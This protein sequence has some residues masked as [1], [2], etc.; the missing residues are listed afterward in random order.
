MKQNALQTQ[1]RNCGMEGYCAIPCSNENT[2]N[3]ELS[4]SL[5]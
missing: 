2:T 5:F 1:N 4:H 3:T